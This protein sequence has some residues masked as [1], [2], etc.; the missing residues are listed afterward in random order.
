[1]AVIRQRGKTFQA[2]VR[3]TVDGRKHEESKTFK[4]ERLANEWA[5]KLEARIKLEGVP[6]RVKSQMTLGELML[7]HMDKVQAVKPMRRQMIWEINRLAVEF[8]KLKLSDMTPKVFSEFAM[9]RAKTGVSGSTILHDLSTI[10]GVLS[11]A[12]VVQGIEVSAEPVTVALDTLHRMGV[13]H[14]SESRDRRP[15][16]EELGRLRQEFQRIAKHP[17]TVIP[18]VVIMDLAIALPRRIGELCAM[19]WADFSGD[20]QYL[21]DTKHPVKPRNELVP[22]PPEARAIIEALPRIDARILPYKEESVTAAFERACDRLNIVDLRYHDLRHH[23]ISLL[24]E[25]G[26]QIQEVA[27]ISGHKSWNVL[28]RYTNLKP[29]NVADTLKS[30][31]K[32]TPVE[33]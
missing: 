23:G 32:R 3:V 11:A 5:D 17:Q 24:F 9:R 4:T 28:K 8:S 33:H 1:M 21:R 15:T 20:L 25:K 16:E 14:H 7:N 26:L 12:Y 6:Q 22:L 10:S 18:S 30:L 2:I 27:M 31:H 29:Q 13:V 19:T